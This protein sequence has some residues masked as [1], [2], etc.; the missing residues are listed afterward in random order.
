VSSSTSSK[1]KV[2]ITGGAGFIGSHM[3][4]HLLAR[5]FE[6][7]VLDC[8]VPQVY[9]GQAMDSDGWP[10]YLNP[11][12]ERMYGNVLNANDV[13]KALVG[14]DYLIHLAASVGVGQSMTN[15]LDYTMNNEVG[16]AAIMQVLTEGKHTVR[17]MIVASSISIYGEG[18]AMRPSTGEIIVPQMRSIE[19]L[20]S[21]SWEVFFETEV[22]IPQPTPETK[23]LIPGSIY[24]INK[25]VQEL[26]FLIMGKAFGIPTAAMRMFNVYGTRQALSNPY[27]GVAAIFISRLKNGQPPL[28]YEDG[29]QRRNFVHVR[30]V[31]RAYGDFLESTEQMWETFNVG[32]PEVVTIAGLARDIAHQMGL[33]IEPEFNGMYRIGDIRHC[34]PDL[35]KINAALGWEAQIKLEDGLPELIEWA[36]GQTAIDMSGDYN[37]DLESRGLLV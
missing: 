7:R 33:R 37:A 21:R 16:S 5:G 25:M 23:P 27:T 32:S 4:D 28:I 17:R 1:G 12:A 8:L 15:I 29:E 14:V 20:R 10:L 24:A 6:V 35:S 31:V 30:D 26:Q 11:E 13:R 3:V 36:G 34:Y 19:Q 9:V 22:L 18:S 2:L